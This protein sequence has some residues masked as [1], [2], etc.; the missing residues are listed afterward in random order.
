MIMFYCLEKPIQWRLSSNYDRTSSSLRQDIGM[1]DSLCFWV[2]DS[3]ET[4]V[5]V[6]IEFFSCYD[7]ESTQSIRGKYKLIKVNFLSGCGIKKRKIPHAQKTLHF[8]SCW[9]LAN[10]IKNTKKARIQPR[11]PRWTIHFLWSSPLGLDLLFTLTG[12]HGPLGVAVACF[13]F[14]NSPSGDHDTSIRGRAA[15]PGPDGLRT[16]ELKWG[17]GAGRSWAKSGRH[18]IARWWPN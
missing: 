18:S 2:Y 8:L 7:S 9:I 12:F 5:T 16:H 10:Q 14:G 13:S 6:W 17:G 3:I 15:V 11:P 4:N 1:I